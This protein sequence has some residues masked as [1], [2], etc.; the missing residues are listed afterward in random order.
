MF[1]EQVKLI[2]VDKGLVTVL[3]S[4][5]KLRGG[6]VMETYSKNFLSS[7]RT[8]QSQFHIVNRNHT[9]V[10]LQAMLKVLSYLL[11]RA[12]VQQTWAVSVCLWLFFYR[13]KGA[14]RSAGVFK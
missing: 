2:Y 3:C 7:L 13:V 12:L 10:V 8:Q 14:F 5:C 9:A 4:V 11:L 6:K 1:S